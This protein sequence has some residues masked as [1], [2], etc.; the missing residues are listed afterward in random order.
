MSLRPILLLALAGAFIGCDSSESSAPDSF[1]A[2]LAV[3]RSDGTTERTIRW[4]GHSDLFQDLLNENATRATFT[5]LLHGE[6]DGHSGTV[7]FRREVQGTNLVPI[8]P[9]RGAFGVGTDDG[10]EASVSA[11]VPST[12]CPD[13]PGVGCPGPAWSY[14]ADAGTLTVT[15]SEPEVIAGRFTFTARL[16]SGSTEQPFG[17]TVRVEGTFRSTNEALAGL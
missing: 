13:G 17:E 2:E 16:L 6:G 4:D 3:L 11:A 9:G 1:Q 8:R 14:A 7:S 5:F 12:V 10:F 15:E